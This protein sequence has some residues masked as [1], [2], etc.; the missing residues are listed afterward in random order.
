MRSP[1][2]RVQPPILKRLGQG[3]RAVYARYTELVKLT[4]VSSGLSAE[5]ERLMRRGEAVR[6]ARGRRM[7]ARAGRG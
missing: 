2:G 3:L 6:A 5:S 4:R 1:L 7:V